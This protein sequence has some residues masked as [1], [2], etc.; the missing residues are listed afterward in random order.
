MPHKR[1]SINEAIEED[2]GIQN[3]YSRQ[4]SDVIEEDPI[5]NRQKTNAIVDEVSEDKEDMKSEDDEIEDNYEIP[6]D[7]ASES[8]NFDFQ[9]RV[10]EIKANTR[11]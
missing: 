11:K 10:N 7:D 5:I 6:D 9:Q 4:Q 3:N 8:S 1:S 2:I